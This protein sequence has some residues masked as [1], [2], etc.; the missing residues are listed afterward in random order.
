MAKNVVKNL[1]QKE[2]M[3][4]ISV[5]T[6]QLDI[7]II[8]VVDGPDW[9]LPQSL[10]LE[11]QPAT[12]RSWN[13]AWQGQDVPIYHLLPEDQTPTS[14]VVLESVTDV[15]RIGL[16]IQGKV[17][18]HAVRI[19]DIKDMDSDRYKQTMAAHYPHL[20][21]LLD[22]ASQAS[23]QR[24]KPRL[25]PQNYVFQPVMFQEQLY[26]IPDVD[27]LSHLLVDLDD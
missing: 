8:P 5:T 1:A 14:I 11:I 20:A 19:A 16:Q 17:G 23:D 7:A 25:V 15:H 26:I 18:Y 3:S 6:G 27:N 2:H 9:I 13:L 24:D 12:E 22:S 4:I 21:A 10:I